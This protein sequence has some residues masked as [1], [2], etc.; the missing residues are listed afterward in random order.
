MEIV[1]V[2]QL[3]DINKQIQKKYQNET[4]E[5][6]LTANIVWNFPQFELQQNDNEHF[7]SISWPNIAFYCVTIKL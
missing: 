3:I 6:C 2:S 7:F 4:K 5:Q 1:F